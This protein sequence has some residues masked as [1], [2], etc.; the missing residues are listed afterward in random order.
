MP[1]RRNSG[2]WEDGV[3]VWA[4]VTHLLGVVESSLLQKVKACMGEEEKKRRN[5]KEKKTKEESLFKRHANL[6]RSFSNF[7]IPRTSPTCSHI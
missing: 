4:L 3:K 2:G 6:V 1:V 7:P 5:E